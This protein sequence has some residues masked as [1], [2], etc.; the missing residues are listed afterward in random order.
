MYRNLFNSCKPSP[1]GWTG[2]PQ[3]QPDNGLQLS[4]MDSTLLLDGQQPGNGPEPE[5]ALDRPRPQPDPE[6]G[7]EPR[8][9]TRPYSGLGFEKSLPEQTTPGA[10]GETNQKPRKT[11]PDLGPTTVVCGKGSWVGGGRGKGLGS[12]CTDIAKISVKDSLAWSVI[13][14]SQYSG[15]ELVEELDLTQ[16]LSRGYGETGDREVG[17]G[18]G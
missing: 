16:S 15:A 9:W 7:P 6:L 8:T 5:P 13:N 12:S 17:V 11:C 14:T 18:G 2:L 3:P 4:L 1:T 10:D